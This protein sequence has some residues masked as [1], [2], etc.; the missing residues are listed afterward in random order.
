VELPAE[1]KPA[2]EE[3]S[4]ISPAK[5]E[6]RELE[7]VSD[8]DDNPKEASAEDAPPSVTDPLDDLD[9]LANEDFWNELETNDGITDTYN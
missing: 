1:D 2:T 4:E 7:S 3:S 5:N 8:D 9:D 6:D